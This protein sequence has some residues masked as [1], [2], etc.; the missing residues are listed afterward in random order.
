[1]HVAAVLKRKGSRIVSAAP[2]DSV[3]AVTRLLTEHRIG[4][5]LVMGDDG[6]PV[7]ILSERDVVRAV[8]RDG[9]AALDRPAADLMTRELI[10]AAPDD[11][12]ADMMAVMTE[13]R[14]RHVP[15]VESGRVVGVISIGDVVKARI[16]DAELEVESLRG[17]VAGMG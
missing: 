10:T 16:D 14:I 13:R 8:A 9:A 7:G 11:T 5:V 17:Y 2:D 3:A 12:V 4:A 1:M 6:H 15:I